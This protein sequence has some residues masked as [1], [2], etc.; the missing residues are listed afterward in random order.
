MSADGPTMEILAKQQRGQMGGRR[1]E[2]TGRDEKTVQ[3][4]WEAKVG[5]AR[6][7]WTP[8][9]LATLSVIGRSI[10]NGEATIAEEFE[11]RRVTAAEIT[12]N[13]ARG[14]QERAGAGRPPIRIR[15]LQAEPTDDDIAAMNDEANAQAA[16]R[17]A[18]QQNEGLFQ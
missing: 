5:A 13:T 2:Q 3:R 6:A 10:K 1:L 14:A 9:D 17:E 15:D 11:P 16:E 7:D 8:H 12:Q 18:D 4:V